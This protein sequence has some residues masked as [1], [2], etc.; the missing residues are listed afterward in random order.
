MATLEL[1]IA[2]VALAV[3]QL[4][5]AG[6]L[7]GSRLELVDG[8]PGLFGDVVLG[9]LV[10]EEAEGQLVSRHQF[11]GR[12][13][14]RAPTHAHDRLVAPKLGCAGQRPSVHRVGSVSVAAAEGVFVELELTVV[15]E[16]AEPAETA[17]E[18]PGG[19][20]AGDREVGVR[21]RLPHRGRE[22]GVVEGAQCRVVLLGQGQ[23]LSTD[24]L[25]VVVAPRTLGIGQDRR[26]DQGTRGKGSGSIV[27]CPKIIASAGDLEEP[28]IQRRRTV[29]PGSGRDRCEALGRE[30]FGDDVH[31]ATGESALHVRSEGLAHHHAVDHRR[32]NEV[33]LR[34]PAPGIGTRKFRAVERGDVVPV[35][36][37]ADD[38][39]SIVRGHNTGDFGGDLGRIAAASPG[40]LLGA[41]GLL[42][43]RS[44][45]PLLEDRGHGAG[46]GGR[47]IEGR[48]GRGGRRRRLGG[49]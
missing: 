48:L 8:L 45:F 35:V 43:A 41:D 17:A 3:G 49:C 21:S 23:P 4:L 29:Q 5:D 40:D 19:V 11:H 1:E 38:D 9:A 31:R 36:Q 37:P 10:V 27:Q 7:F 42:G 30:G 2:Q 14:D 18:E 12:A 33:Q 16:G 44:V 46:L 47:L 24:C 25:L 20:A 13:R 32:G 34:G 22:G 6:A 15:I 28:V 39:L 26:V